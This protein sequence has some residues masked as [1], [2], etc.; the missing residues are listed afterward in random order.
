[1]KYEVW[2]VGATDKRWEW[3]LG[4]WGGVNL[5]WVLRN[6]KPLRWGPEI[7]VLERT[8]MEKKADERLRVRDTGDWSRAGNRN[9]QGA[10]SEGGGQ[11]SG[12][13]LGWGSGEEEKLR[14]GPRCPGEDGA[15]ISW[16]EGQAVHSLGTNAPS[17]SC[18]PHDPRENCLT[19]YASGSPSK[20]EDDNNMTS[21][22]IALL[23]GLNKITH[24]KH[25][26]Q[27][28]EHPNPQ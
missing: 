3:K 22:S 14:L 9:S 20:N 6:L 2:R 18:Q 5:V 27:C 7:C 10:M 17:S 24:V 1:M 8:T 4:K 16:E 13:C 26:E 19:L 15:A 25:S 21:Q 28:L 12:N 11:D 23:C